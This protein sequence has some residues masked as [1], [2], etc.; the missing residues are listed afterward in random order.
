MDRGRAI[1]RFAELYVFAL[2]VAALLTIVWLVAPSVAAVPQLAG[3]WFAVG[4]FGLLVVLML[5]FM[6]YTR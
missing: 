5:G 4:G 3:I 1:Y 6:A 2:V